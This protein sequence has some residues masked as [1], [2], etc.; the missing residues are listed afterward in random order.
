MKAMIAAPGIAEPHGPWNPGLESEIPEELRPLG[1]L[2]RGENVS[3]GVA[4][5]RE[6]RGLTGLG[7]HDFVA[8]RPGRLALHEVLIR[9]SANLSVPDG[10]RVE[11]LGINFRQMTSRVMAR[12]QPRMGEVEARY[13]TCRAQLKSLIEAELAKLTPEGAAQ[14]IGA[15]DARAASPGPAAASAALA[16]LSR[17]VS[18]VLVRHGRL[19]GP[20]EVIGAVALGIACNDHAAA[21]IGRLV[22]PWLAAI[23]RDEGFRVLPAQANPIVMNTKGAS[24][25]GKTTIRPLQ[26]SLAATIGADWGEF[27][28]VSPDIWR[29]QLLDYASLGEAYKY[30]GPFTGEELRIVDQKLD[31]YVAAK[32]ERGEMTHMLIDRF[33]FDSFAPHSDEAGSNLLTRFGREIYLFFMITPPDHLVERAWNRGLEVGR[34][35][36]VDDTLA[37]AVEAYS[38][39]PQL[40]FTWVQRADKRVH[41]EFLDNAVAAGARPLTA[42]FGWNDEMTILDPRPLV[43]VERFRHLDVNA[44]SPEALF[45]DPAAI[46]AARNEG[47]LR[48]CLRRFRRVRF[49]ERATQ[50]VYRELENGQERAVDLPLSA[51]ERRHTVGRWT[52]E[53]R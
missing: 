22:E 27:A 13:A 10:Q 43:D 16:A 25:S 6:I 9:V 45:P 26:R 31:A 44:R 34:Y 40:F 17:V 29:K 52:A 37:H 50:R 28:L 36:A 5:A 23:A 41:F 12:L 42:A 47:F 3:T 15:W 2:L 4:E 48:E 49:A 8:F 14:A 30:A 51:G 33:R 11:D 24:A 20:R 53:E 35:K 39:M 46:E 7:Y 19:W 18:A 1:T 32:A 21:E 38:G